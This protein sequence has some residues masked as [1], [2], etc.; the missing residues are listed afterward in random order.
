MILLGLGSNLN[1][2]FGD[3]FENINLAIAFLEKKNLKVLKKSSYYETPS[4]PDIKNPKF[5]NVVIQ[6]ET[7]IDAM[8]VFSIIIDAEK[9]VERKRGNKNDPRTCDIDIIDFN[10]ESKTFIYKE[11][12]FIVPHKDLSFRNFVLYPLKEI[13]PNWK[14]PVTKE[15]IAMMIEK[16]PAE[17]KMSILMVKKY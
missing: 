15:S 5:I 17:D 1:S 12:K 4:Y 7:Y 2:S 6:I 9:A 16:L 3:R 13:A 11:H 14:H 8:S 10:N